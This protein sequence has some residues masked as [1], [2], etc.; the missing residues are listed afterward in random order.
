MFGDPPRLG[1]GQGAGWVR[2]ERPTFA[3]AKLTGSITGDLQV[4]LLDALAKGAAAP[5]DPGRLD[6]R[7]QLKLTRPLH[8][9]PRDS[10]PQPPSAG[11]RNTPPRSTGCGWASTPPWARR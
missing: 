10:L 7:H 8:F 11:R 6:R 3:A 2:L 1:R 4:G 9:A 5:I